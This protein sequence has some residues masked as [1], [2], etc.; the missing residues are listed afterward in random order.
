MSRGP[1]CGSS[2]WKLVRRCGA[3]CGFRSACVFH[4]ALAVSSLVFVRRSRER[5]PERVDASKYAYF[6][7]QLPDPGFGR[8]EHHPVIYKRGCG[9]GRYRLFFHALPSPGS[10]PYSG[11][12]RTGKEGYSRDVP[13]F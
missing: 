5:V 1:F 13:I 7:I 10:V 3:D 9:S 8:D 4:N 2:G 11:T 12:L 6:D